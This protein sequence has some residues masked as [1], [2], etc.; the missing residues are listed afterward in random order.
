MKITEENEE[1]IIK[2]NTEEDKLFM[3]HA[4]FTSM[5]YS[6]K[7]THKDGFADRFWKWSNESYD[8]LNPFIINEARITKRMLQEINDENGTENT[9]G[10]E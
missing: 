9:I 2:L 3:M 10:T 7:S 6:D 5:A 1:I 4:L 8:K